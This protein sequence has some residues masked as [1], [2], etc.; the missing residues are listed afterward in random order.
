MGISKKFF[1]FVPLRQQLNSFT[2]LP[3][4]FSVSKINMLY[5]WIHAASVLMMHR[6]TW[7]D[8][9]DFLDKMNKVPMRIVLTGMTFKTIKRY[10]RETDSW[11]QEYWWRMG[12]NPDLMHSCGT[13]R[14]RRRG[15][16]LWS[17]GCP[18]KADSH[19]TQY[20]RLGG[21]PASTPSP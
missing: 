17:T 19:G 21:K 10:V 18:S 15:A 12:S 7:P 3:M 6:R 5:R 4:G 8:F 11:D 1:S 16:N 20:W 13:R 14:C 2:R 9:C